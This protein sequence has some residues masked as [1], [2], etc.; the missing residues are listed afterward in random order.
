M[1]NYSLTVYCSSLNIKYTFP[2][3]DI[4]DDIKFVERIQ[5]NKVDIPGVKSIKFLNKNNCLLQVK[6]AIQLILE[7]IMKIE[8][9]KIELIES[10]GISWERICN[11]CFY[12]KLNLK[13]K[14]SLF[15]R[16]DL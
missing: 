3:S 9:L 5:T 10:D 13:I 16:I 14:K 1:N 4:T 6:G 12:N 2:I 8:N 15:K 11:I 7:D